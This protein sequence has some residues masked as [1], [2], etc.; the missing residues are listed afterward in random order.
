M[1]K[2]SED[3]KAQNELLDKVREEQMNREKLNEM[4][5]YER[6]LKQF[7]TKMY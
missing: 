5:N 1:K 3:A 2:A 4:D 6:L 7:N